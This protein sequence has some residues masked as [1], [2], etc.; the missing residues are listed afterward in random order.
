MYACQCSLQEANLTTSNHLV[1]SAVSYQPCAE[2]DGGFDVGIEDDCRHLRVCKTVKKLISGAGVRKSWTE[3]T[4]RLG[5]WF[6]EM[7][8]GRKVALQRTSEIDVVQ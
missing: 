5:R 2:V 7:T 8:R 4:T 3:I 1:C 6:G